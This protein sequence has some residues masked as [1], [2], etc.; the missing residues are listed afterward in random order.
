[1]SQAEAGHHGG[2]AR[3]I[4]VL[5]NHV[6]MEDGISAKQL[7]Q[8]VDAHPSTVRNWIEDL[9]RQGWPIG[10]KNGYGYFL[11]ASDEEFRAV[12]A[13]MEERRASTAETMS[14]LAGA[15]YGPGKR[16]YYGSGGG[17]GE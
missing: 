14:A 15:F 16:F 8:R 2:L 13:S 17:D 4:R 1:M 11:I 3:T 10:S 12:M 6:G 5:Q 7:A 9:R